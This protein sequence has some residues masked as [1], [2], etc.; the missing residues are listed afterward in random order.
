MNEAQL[1]FQMLELNSGINKR[2]RER[3]L[4][5]LLLIDLT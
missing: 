4:I 1:P 5:V 3:I 2:E